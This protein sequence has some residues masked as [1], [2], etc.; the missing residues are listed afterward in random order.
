MAEKEERILVL[1]THNKDGKCECV[2]QD[3]CHVND[4]CAICNVGMTRQEVVKCMAKAIRK[5]LF[6]NEGPTQK[7]KEEG[8]E[9]DYNRYVD[10]MCEYIAEA[11]LN[12]LLEY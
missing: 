10:F 7:I 9:Q 3:G 1:T 8:L 2:T 12:S 6:K 4:S 11:A 5:K